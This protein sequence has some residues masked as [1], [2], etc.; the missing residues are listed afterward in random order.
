MDWIDAGTLGC[1][2]FATETGP[3]SW[4]DALAYCLMYGN[5][6]YLAEIHNEATQF[7]LKGYAESLPGVQVSGW[8]IGATDLSH[9]TFDFVSYPSRVI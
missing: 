2:H 7:I 5:G 1:F 6:F 9:V 4:Y 8:W 3:K